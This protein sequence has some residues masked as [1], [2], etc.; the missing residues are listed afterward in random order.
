M[1]GYRGTGVALLLL[2]KI[3]QGGTAVAVA[4][5]TYKVVLCVPRRPGTPQIFPKMLLNNAFLSGVLPGVDVLSPP[6]PFCPR[7]VPVIDGFPKV[8]I[9][10]QHRALAQFSIRPE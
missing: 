7:D 3:E 6:S 9:T 8:L 2:R 10:G 1:R 5:S 4:L